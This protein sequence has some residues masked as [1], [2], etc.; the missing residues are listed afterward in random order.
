MYCLEIWLCGSL[1]PDEWELWDCHEF[2]GHVS[3]STV[4][5][6]EAG[7]GRVGVHPLVRHVVL[8]QRNYWNMN[9]LQSTSSP[10]RT[11]LG[12]D[13]TIFKMY[14]KFV[15]QIYIFPKMHW[16]VFLVRYINC[17]ISGSLLSLTISKSLQKCS[18]RMLANKPIC[19]VC[20]Q[21]TPDNPFDTLAKLNV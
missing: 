17:C 16:L 7:P 11:S 6:E 2:L 1:Y 12:D 3:D 14:W 20:C 19:R 9:L 10:A 21:W 8:P 13:V 5:E 4:C 15:R 18:Y